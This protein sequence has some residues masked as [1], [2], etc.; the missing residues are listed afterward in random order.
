VKSVALLAALVVVYAAL[1]LPFTRHLRQRPF[2]EKVGYVPQ[3]FILQT[4][5]AD[6]RYAMAAG[7][8]FN[9]LAY[10]G[11]LVEKNLFGVDIPPDYSTMQT[12]LITASRLDPYNMD[13]YYFAQSMAW[14]SNKTRETTELLE[15]GMRYRDWDFYL[16]FFA[17]FN[18]A[19]FLKDYAAAAPHFA[20][21]ARLSGSDLFTRLASRYMY[22]AGQT[23]LAIDYLTAMIQSSKNEAIKKP[24]QT[25]HAAL[26][27]VRRIEQARDA[28][29]QKTGRL[30][31]S[32]VELQDAGV[33]A[34]PPGDPYGG[35]FYLDPDG[36]VRTTS[37]FANP[38]QDNQ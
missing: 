13:I 16:P 15:Y 36:T 37:K 4:L 32:I 30:P 26:L 38:S 14:N 18:Y 7:L 17:G 25:R 8:V 23:G 3:P 2:L 31:K 27:E 35:E 28:F 6:Q 19:Y 5:A 29:R 22:E 9:V 33:L 24:F 12:T 21:A 10:Y 20:T 34:P 11:T 1:L